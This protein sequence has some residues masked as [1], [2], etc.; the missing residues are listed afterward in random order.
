MVIFKVAAARNSDPT[1]L[2]LSRTLM[3]VKV[4]PWAFLTLILAFGIYY[5]LSLAE[6]SS[7]YSVLLFSGFRTFNEVKWEGVGWGVN[8]FQFTSTSH[9]FGKGVPS[10]VFSLRLRMVIYCDGYGVCYA[11]ASKIH[12]TSLRQIWVLLGNGWNS[13]FPLQQRPNCWIPKQQ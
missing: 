7:G 10:L 12:V 9:Y 3:P 2:N 11:T 8:P 6:S 13:V 4:N 1:N 5:F